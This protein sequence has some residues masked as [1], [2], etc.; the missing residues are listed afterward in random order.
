MNY[1]LINKKPAATKMTAGFSA[2]P[3]PYHMLCFGWSAVPLA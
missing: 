1:Q 2:H 3:F